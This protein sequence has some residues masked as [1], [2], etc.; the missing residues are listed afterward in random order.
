MAWRFQGPLSGLSENLIKTVTSL[1]QKHTHFTYTSGE[2]TDF[3]V[4]SA[5]GT[6]LRIPALGRGTEK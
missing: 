6:R 5:M 4:L 3:L 2:F 1:Y